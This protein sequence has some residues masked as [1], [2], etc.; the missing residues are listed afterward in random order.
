MGRSLK[1]GPYVDEACRSN[2]H[3]R[4]GSVGPGTSP[5]RIWKGSRMP[6]H[7]GNEQ[8]TIRNLRVVNVDVEK[9]LLYL[10]G[11]VPGP[12]GGVLIIKKT[13]P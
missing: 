11:S 10:K 13:A 7:Y 8:Q 1:K 4:V 3:R 9:C 2:H 5:G 6:G 12:S